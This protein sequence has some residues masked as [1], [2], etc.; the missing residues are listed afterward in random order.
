MTS[1]HL[2]L[3]YSG[4]TD[5]QL[6]LEFALTTLHLYHIS[7]QESNPEPL[8]PPYVNASVLAKHR[9]RSAKSPP[10]YEAGGWIGCNN[11]LNLART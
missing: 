2:T 11:D 8:K 5:S 4:Q 9:G 7:A 3:R 6:A 1:Q 10:L